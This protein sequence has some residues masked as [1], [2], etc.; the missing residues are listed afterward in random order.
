MPDPVSKLSFAPITSSP[1]QLRSSPTGGI[2]PSYSGTRAQP[3][4][5]GRGSQSRHTPVLQVSL[6]R[7]PNNG[8]DESVAYVDV[9]TPVLALQA[10]G[11]EHWIAASLACNII[12]SPNLNL[13]RHG[14]RVAIKCR[15]PEK[16]DHHFVHQ[17]RIFDKLE[18]ESN[19]FGALPAQNR[20]LTMRNL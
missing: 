14:S 20:R 5:K 11:V 15:S 2:Q 12:F 17:V 9:R 16:V 1:K 10:V 7:L 6:R 8:A 18:R 19:R 13:L 4:G 3:K